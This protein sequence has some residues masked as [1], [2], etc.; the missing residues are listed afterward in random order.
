MSGRDAMSARKKICKVMR[1][2]QGVR[3]YIDVRM[4]LEM[5]IVHAVRPQLL[6]DRLKYSQSIVRDDQA[7]QEPCTA[8]T[9]CYTPLMAGSVICSLVKRFVSEEQIPHRVILDLATWT[10]ITN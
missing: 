7:L 10:L 3:L 8:R 5:L 2:Q 1:E 4:R 9:I 6:N